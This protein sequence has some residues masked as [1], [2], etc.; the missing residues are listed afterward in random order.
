MHMFC[1]EPEPELELGS[2]LEPELGPDLELELC[3][4]CSAQA[5]CFTWACVGQHQAVE[6]IGVISREL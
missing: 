4:C 6:G 5:T 3:Q 1:K 2:E